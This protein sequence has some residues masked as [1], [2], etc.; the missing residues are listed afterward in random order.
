MFQGEEVLLLIFALGGVTLKLAD[1]YGERGSRFGYIFAAVSAMCMGLLIS[2][3]PASSSIIL[4]IIV[5]VV[6][7]GKVNRL[8]MLSGLC[9]V[10]TAAIILGFAPPRIQLLAAVAV[11][12][13]LDEVGHDR[14][15]VRG[16]IAFFF[17]FRAILKVTMLLLVALM[18]VDLVNALGFFC[19]DISYDVMDIVLVRMGKEK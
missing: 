16:G 17:R 6:V 9:L 7:A 2:D 10:L 1:F 11:A 14:F 5:G 3:N 13:V 12:A 18:W 19:F 15:T 8:S 4:G